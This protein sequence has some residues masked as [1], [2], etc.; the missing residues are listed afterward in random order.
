MSAP[1]GPSE[2]SRKGGY[3]VYRFPSSA[4]QAIDGRPTGETIRAFLD[5]VVAERLPRL[6]A[7]LADLGLQAAGPARPH[8][9]RSRNHCS[10]G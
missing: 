8:D 6:V 2:P 7:S 1:H 10:A 3:R 9:F 5:R 4:R